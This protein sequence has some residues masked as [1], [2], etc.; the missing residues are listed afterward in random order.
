MFVSEISLSESIRKLA[1]VN[2]EQAPDVVLKEVINDIT[3]NEESRN[4][5]DAQ[6]KRALLTEEI[7]SELK[8]DEDDTCFNELIKIKKHFLLKNSIIQTYERKK[9]KKQR[10]AQKL[11]L[12]N[13]YT[14]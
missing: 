3:N 11:F 6:N 5:N 2:E 1:N 13:N 4:F 14:L 10:S 8:T 7:E 9:M 12:R